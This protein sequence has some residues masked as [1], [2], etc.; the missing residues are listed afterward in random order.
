MEFTKLVIRINTDCKN[1]DVN[2]SW[3]DFE[4][5]IGIT[6]YDFFELFYFEK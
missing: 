2:V 5:K 6:K 1:Y 4:D 3:D